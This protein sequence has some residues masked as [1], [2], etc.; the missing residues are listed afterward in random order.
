MPQYAILQI[1][2]M[3]EE[4]LRCFFTCRLCHVSHGNRDRMSAHKK[5]S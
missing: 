3:F 2:T 4:S 1:T 5:R